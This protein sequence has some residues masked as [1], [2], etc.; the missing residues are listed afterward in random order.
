VPNPTQQITHSQIG[1]TVALPLAHYSNLSL[2]NGSTVGQTPPEEIRR[3]L[4]PFIERASTRPITEV[5]G[6]YAK[7]MRRVFE[8]AGERAVTDWWKEKRGQSC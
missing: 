8:D 1:S 3:L 2:P 7:T 4:A 5:V 6:D